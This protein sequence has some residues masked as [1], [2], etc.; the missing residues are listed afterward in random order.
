MSWPDSVTRIECTNAKTLGVRLAEDTSAQLQKAIQ[1]RGSACLL[2]SGGST[3]LPFFQA[4]SDRDIDWSRVNIALV[5]ERWVDP[6]HADSN[7]RLVRENLVIGRASAARFISSVSADGSDKREATAMAALPGYA[8]KMHSLLHAHEGA[9]DVT[10]LGMGSDAHTASL[11]PASSVSNIGRHPTD[12]LQ[13]IDG[14]D[15]SAAEL[16]TLVKPCTA[17]H[18]RLSLTF[19]GIFR[20]RSLLLHIVGDEKREVLSQALQLDDHTVAPIAAVFRHADPVVYW[21]S[22]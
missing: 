17:P 11:F 10:V 13:I 4:L 8:E 2:V 7:E 3:P 19:S 22:D 5:D 16:V 14:N 15:L 12:H 9:F 18:E 6:D 20:S 21:S 1:T